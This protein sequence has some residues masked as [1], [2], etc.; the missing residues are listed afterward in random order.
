MTHE[1]KIQKIGNS[2]GLILPEEVLLH[3]KVA[4][5]DSM[6]LTE[7]RDGIRLTASTPEFAKTMAVFENL[8]RRYRN[9]LD[10]L[11]K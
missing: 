1:L 3:L 6:I 5:G 8:N 9:T 7:S 2:V 11:E 4:E 10:E